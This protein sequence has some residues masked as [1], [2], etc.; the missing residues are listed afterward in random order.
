MAL[1]HNEAMRFIDK[2]Q[3][4][5]ATGCW[6][7]TGTISTPG[8]RKWGGYG[9][10]W[11][12]GK[13]VLAHRVM[14][15][16]RVGPIPAGY[17]VDHVK[18]C[19]NRHC[20]RH[21]EAVTPKENVRRSNGVGAKNARK[22]ICKHGHPFT[23]ENTKPQKGGRECHQCR[24]DIYRRYHRRQAEKCAAALVERCT[25]DKRLKGYL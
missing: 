9:R 8:K 10:F 23:P 17:E 24:L 7:W 16:H 14:H 15:E 3:Y 13:E 18:P 6:L 20:V 2:L 22:T 21:T 4:D 19:P 5:G 25:T 11:L 12:R 1:T